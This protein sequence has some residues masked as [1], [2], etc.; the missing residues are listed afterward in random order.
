M[1]PER[2]MLA[3]GR[4]FGDA[5]KEWLELQPGGLAELGERW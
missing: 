4:E 5:G 3:V 1:I 2:M